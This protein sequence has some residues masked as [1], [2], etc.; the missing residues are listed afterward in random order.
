M[1]FGPQYER[2]AEFKAA[3]RLY[4][5]KYRAEVLGVD[6]QD[7]GNRLTDADAK[8]LLNYYPELNCRKALRKRYPSYSRK[9][10]AD[11]LHL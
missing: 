10:D 2:D 3:A 11:L 6:F 8:A 9:R 4:Q 5:S 1:N 7:Y